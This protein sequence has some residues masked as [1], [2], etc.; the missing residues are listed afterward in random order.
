MLASAVVKAQVSANPS[1]CLGNA[2]IS[3]QVNLLVFDAAPTA[4]DEDIISAYA[5]LPSMLMATP[6]AFAARLSE[7]DAAVCPATGRTAAVCGAY[8]LRPVAQPS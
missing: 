1:A 2:G 8:A 4:L 3:A 5:P 7:Q 6:A